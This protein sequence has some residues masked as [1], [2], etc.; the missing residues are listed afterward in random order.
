MVTLG[1]IV[2]RR[3]VLRRRKW[4]TP[5]KNWECPVG[6]VAGRF[7]AV[8]HI[9]ALSQIR[10]T[11]QPA[12]VC[13]MLELVSFIRS[14]ARLIPS[15]SIS[16]YLAITSQCLSIAMFDCYNSNSVS[17]ESQKRQIR[18]FKF[19]QTNAFLAA[20]PYRLAPLKLERFRRW[21]NPTVLRFPFPRKTPCMT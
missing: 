5:Y 16:W 6:F 10:G 12:N 17:D 15:L 1:T 21:A 14:N 18:D 4:M 11:P 3:R 9:N 2:S 13:S 8:S 19:A 20:A 7:L